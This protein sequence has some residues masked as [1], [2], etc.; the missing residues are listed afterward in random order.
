M[1]LRN[2]YIQIYYHGFGQKKVD[3][4]LAEVFNNKVILSYL[5]KVVI[6]IKRAKFMNFIKIRLH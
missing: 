1:K 4:I 5:I 3:K 6:L 2:L